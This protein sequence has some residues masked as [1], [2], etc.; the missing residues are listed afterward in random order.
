MGLLGAGE[1]AGRGLRPLRGLENHLEEAL[2]TSFRLTYPKL[3]LIFCVEDETDPVV[4]LVRRLIAEHPAV[5]ARLLVGRDRLGGNPK[6]DNLTKGWR[7]ASADWIIMSDSNAL[8]PADFVES[9]MS[10]WRSDTGLVSTAAYV[11]RPEGFAAEIEC[12]FVNTFQPAG[13][14][15]PI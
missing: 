9:L 10:R 4:P 7:A 15:S 6:V 1:G 5:D 3:E 13:C 8:L 11:T 12:A 14:C 2:T